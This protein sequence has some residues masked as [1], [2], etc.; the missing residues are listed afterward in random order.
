MS[1]SLVGSEMCIRDSPPRPGGGP[2]CACPRSAS[3]KSTRRCTGRRS[4]SGKPPAPAP[5]AGAAAGSPAAAS[6]TPA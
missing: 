5:A 4:A 6:R 1:A 3:A 2:R